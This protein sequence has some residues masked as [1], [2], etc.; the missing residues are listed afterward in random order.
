MSLKRQL[1]LASLL[2][3]LIPWAGLHFVLELDNAL[4]QQALQQLEAQGSRL[5]EMVGDWLLDTPTATDNTVIYANTT[6]QAVNIDG[7]G[8]EWPGFDEGDHPA[9]W[10]TAVRHRHR[11]AGRRVTIVSFCTC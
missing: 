2:M 10:Q 3:L 6:D 7:Y 11:F 9:P 5:A 8:N 4:R 1:L